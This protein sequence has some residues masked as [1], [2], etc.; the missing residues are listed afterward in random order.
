LTTLISKNWCTE[1]S[2]LLIFLK[3]GANAERDKPQAKKAAPNFEVDKRVLRQYVFEKPSCRD[4][5]GKE[6]EAVAC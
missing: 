1:N 4:R 6:H 2:L 3:E 5:V